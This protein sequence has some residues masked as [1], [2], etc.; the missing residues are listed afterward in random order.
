MHFLTWHLTGQRKTKPLRVLISPSTV[1]VWCE[2]R[3]TRCWSAPAGCTST[4]FLSMS[5]GATCPSSLWCI[6]VSLFSIFHNISHRH[7]QDT[8]HHH[9]FLSA[10]EEI[11]LVHHQTPLA[12]TG[13]MMRTQYEW[14]FVSMKVTNKT[15]CTFQQQQ[16]VLI[17]TVSQQIYQSIWSSWEPSLF[18][19]LL[20]N[21]LPQITMKRRPQ[22][23]IVNF[24]LP[25]FFFLCLDLASF[26]ISNNGGEKLSFKVTVLLAVTVMQLILN[27]I[28]PSSSERIPLIGEEEGLQQAWAN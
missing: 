9:P 2:S 12:A 25:V 10:V 28:L 19:F 14:L 26:L 4:N 18:L 24:L 8:I 15:I 11:E 1:T 17:F 22:L 7:L 20:L 5:R 27:E 6:L 13:T 3:T 23:Y 16:D 21:I